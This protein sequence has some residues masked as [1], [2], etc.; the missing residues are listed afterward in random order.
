M[1]KAVAAAYEWDD[2]DLGH[3]FHETKQGIR[4]TIS[5]TAR[6]E[7]LQRLLKLNHDRYD[8][9]VKEGKHDKK[10]GAAKKPKAEKAPPKPKASKNLSLGRYVYRK[11]DRE[12][13][14]YMQCHGS[15]HE[16]TIGGTQYTSNGSFYF[17]SRSFARKHTNTIF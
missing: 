15:D 8:A 10:K 3:G 12:G 9:E 13:S 16:D 1:D 4:F 11:T 17:L 2:L 6:R 14:Q 5:E 7:V